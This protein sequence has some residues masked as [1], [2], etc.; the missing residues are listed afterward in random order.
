MISLT[1]FK[2]IQLPDIPFH[3]EK[4]YSFF[5]KETDPKVVLAKVVNCFDLW[6]TN[7]NIKH[8]YNITK[9]DYII[10][11]TEHKISGELAYEWRFVSLPPED[12]VDHTPDFSEPDEFR[13][14]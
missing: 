12:G 3:Y 14:R 8:G 5:V 10:S 1:D 11:P 2:N 9:V 6:P 7:K 13:D 4:F